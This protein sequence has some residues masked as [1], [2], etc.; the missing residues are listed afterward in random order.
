[1]IKVGFLMPESG[2]MAR[3]I[4]AYAKN[5]LEELHKNKE[6]VVEQ[7]SSFEEVD[8]D[9]DLVH[10]PFFDLFYKTLP[11]N[12]KKPTIVTIHDVIP[13]VFPKY[14]PPGLKGF[15]RL[16]FQKHAL[17]NVAAVITDSDQSKKDI[18]KYLNISS[19]K[20][21]VT[22]LAAGDEFKVIKDQKLLDQVKKKYKLPDRFSL[23]TGSTNWNKNI[24]SIAQ[25]SLAADIDVVFIGKSFEQRQNLDHLE[26][27]SFKQFLAKYEFHPS[28]H[29]LG[30]VPTE[31]L[32]P[33]IN[34][35]SVAMLPSYYEGFGLPILEAQSCG[36]PVIAGNNSS[37][38]EVVGDGAILVDPTNVHEITEA[39]NKIMTHQGT[40]KM[41][42]E[43]G[44]KNIKRYSWEKCAD[45]T[46]E[47][48]K[49][50][51]GF[52]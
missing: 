7:I 21:H 25:A 10:T 27:K 32:V 30:F 35:A 33:I 48:Y 37:M 24:S 4:G 14:Y 26:L 2:H 22:Y 44:F 15:L 50:V 51:K 52:E 28:I 38:I 3:G 36:V 1:M 8:G 31:D 5:L 40:R 34:L 11:R 41:L 29:I 13:L 16:Q 18:A 9:M 46:V 39:I 49:K 19:N 45:Q 43:R 42:I 17:N 47:I 20:I 6:V 23:F 12:I